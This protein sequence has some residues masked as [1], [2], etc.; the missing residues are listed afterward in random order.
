MRK[1]LCLLVAALAFLSVEMLPP[2]SLWAVA[3]V[4]A[5]NTPVEYGVGSTCDAAWGAAY[6]AAY[7]YA[8]SYCAARCARVCLFSFPGHVGESC[9]GTGPYG[10]SSYGTFGC[11]ATT[12][13]TLPQQ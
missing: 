10:T 4:N 9:N 8:T 13:C 7:N 1:G 5:G 6:T 11:A 12:P 2:Q 3:C